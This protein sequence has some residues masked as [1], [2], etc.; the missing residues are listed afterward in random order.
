ECGNTSSVSQTITVNDDTA[1]VP[2]AAPADLNL[3]CASDVP[4]AVNLTAT[5]NCDGDIIVSPTAN[6]TPG[7]CANDFV[8]VRT[9][10]FTDDCGNTSSVSQTIT[11]N[12]DTPPVIT[13]PAD[14]TLE[15]GPNLDISP[16]NTGSATATDNCGG[17]PTI[18]FTDVV[19]PGNCIGQTTITRTWTATD[20]C[21]NQSSCDQIITIGDDSPPTITCPPDV[22]LECVV[23][24]DTSPA[25]TGTATAT[26]S[27]DPNPD[28]S[29]SDVITPGDCPG[30]YIITRTWTATD[31]CGN[32]TSCDQTIEVDDTVAPIPPAPPADLNLQ[33]A[34]DVPP[35]SD[36]KALDDCQGDI[37]GVPNDVVTPGNCPNSFS[38]LRTWTFTDDCGNTSSVSHTITVNDDTAPV[39]PAPPADLNVQ[40]ASDVPA[41]VDLTATDNCD[42]DII[43]SPTA[44]ITPGACANDFVMVRTWTFTDECGNTSSVSQTITVNDDTAP[45][46][47]APP[48]DLN[49]QCASDVPAAVDLTATD[50]CDGD[51]TVSP[52]ANTTPGA[53]A[54]DFVM[55]RTWTFT[56]SC[57]NTSSVSQTITVNDDT[58][59]VPPAPPSDIAICEDESLPAAEDLTAVDNCDGDIT[60]SPTEESTPGSNGYTLVR[61]WTFT[62][63]CGNSSSV[64]QSIEV[65]DLPEIIAGNPVCSEGQEFGTYSVDV[66]TDGEE[67]TSDFGTVTYNGGNS[68]T[69]S[70]IANGQNVTVTATSELGCKTTLEI[71]APDCLCIE[72]DFD[73]TNITCLGLNDG[74]I[75]VNFVTPGA[76]VKVNGLPYDP[77]T[78]YGPGEYLVEAYFEG[79]D[80]PDCYISELIEILEPEEVTVQ[81]TSTNITC[82]GADDGTITVFGLSENA[83]YVIQK[84]GVGPD[85]SGQDY[86]GP[87]FYIIS[88]TVCDDFIYDTRS[89]E[90]C[91]AVASVTI[92]EPN[93]I[94]CTITPGYSKYAN[95]DDPKYNYLSID[96]FGGTY[97]LTFSWS[98]NNTSVQN[99]WSLVSGMDSQIVYFEPGAQSYGILY[100][101]ITDANGCIQFVQYASKSICD[102]NKGAINYDV[103][104]NPVKDVLMI[105]FKK[106]LDADTTIEVFDLLGNV[107]YSNVV[108]KNELAKLDI[109]FRG[110]PSTIYYLK[111]VNKEGTTIKKI[112]LDR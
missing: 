102:D 105:D 81:A 43:V 99:G 42:G 71:T 69:V 16:A 12:D 36:L 26:D 98:L 25:N 48:A 88:A 1:P 75:T 91:N 34:D 77:E 3:Q 19:T 11:V 93:E 13:C 17:D 92:S 46:P 96:T 57:G 20:E 87:G 108:K 106:T 74:T 21:G 54:N 111:I 82:P 103:Y 62:D 85:L 110:F 100:C 66:T 31:D 40:C 35:A 50:N 56:D 104:P 44:N 41:A 60:V 33:C 83:C 27:N 109:D 101:E 70:D 47:P 10:T 86:F 49:L 23:G 29:F 5:D 24:L 14:L 61:T 28:V 97:P 68:W 89:Y 95:C 39:P 22:V 84:N 52:T 64:S 18:E 73:W 107:A 51:I 59:P 45:V 80:D 94:T 53:C 78:L 32:Q 4:A 2:P 76:V 37:D 79:N 38:I 15:A 6:I 7:T 8:M 30:S 112:I 72:L 55:V 9:W 63:L 67:L 58:A 90:P 65:E